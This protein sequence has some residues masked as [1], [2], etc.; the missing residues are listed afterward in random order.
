VVGLGRRADHGDSAGHGDLDTDG[1]DH[2]RGSMDQQ[3][4]PPAHRE[5]A[6]D[7]VGG[8][9]GHRQRGGRLPVQAGRFEREVRGQGVLG[10]GTG[11]RPDHHLVAARHTSDP[12]PHLVD[13]AGALQAGDGG[14][15]RG[16]HL[17]GPAPTDLEVDGIHGSG[18]DL[19][20][21]LP[22]PGVRL[23]HLRRPQ[24]LRTAVLRVGDGL[25]ACHFPSYEWLGVPKLAERRMRGERH[26]GLRPTAHPSTAFKEEAQRRASADTQQTLP[27]PG[28]TPVS[29]PRS[30]AAR[31][32]ARPSLRKP[33]SRTGT[34]PRV[35]KSPPGRSLRP[36]GAA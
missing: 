9:D 16:T 14:E 33:V 26:A 10:V 34:W 27:G 30:W 23:R 17:R 29:R 5:L 11:V 12:W 24:N 2:A 6:Q 32:E 19:H 25:H 20:A 31:A 4:L 36:C 22:R 8:L 1:S 13:D 15:G 7:T 21:H 35:R 3:G 28:Q 18:H